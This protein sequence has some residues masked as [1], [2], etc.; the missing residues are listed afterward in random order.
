MRNRTGHRRNAGS[1]KR[2]D[3]RHFITTSSG[4]I[5]APS[6]TLFYCLV[7]HVSQSVHKA[8]VNGATSILAP[9]CFP[10]PVGNIAPPELAEAHRYCRKLAVEHYENFPVFLRLFAPDQQKALAAVYAFARTADDFAD[11]TIFDPIALRALA[12]WR[13]ALRAAASGEASHPVFVA[14]RWAMKRYPIQVAHLEALLDAFEQD[15]VK[16]RYRDWDDLHDYCSRSANP[17]GRIVLAV[18]GVA[19]PEN[20]RR[21]DAM[22]TAL[23]LTNFWQDISVDAQK[24]RIYLPREL[25]DRH[26]VSEEDILSGTISHG[27]APLIAKAC[28]HTAALFR[29]GKPLI[30]SVPMPGK[31]YLA[32]VHIGGTT[33]LAMTRRYGPRLLR[34]RPRLSLG[35]Y[36]SSFAPTMFGGDTP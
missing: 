4:T 9:W 5:V 24:G 8:E 29:E 12:S 13:S 36:L 26:G 30:G 20:E 22:C 6:R 25:L 34:R 11:E 31:A 21:S 1:V 2:K 19:T 28:A 3:T 7:V 10:A 17:V 15:R 16:K 33:M 32:L 14:L 18:L 27:I 35:S 23:Q